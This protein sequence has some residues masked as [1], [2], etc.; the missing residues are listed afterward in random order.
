[1][2][3]FQLWKKPTKSFGAQ[4]VHAPIINPV[5]RSV[6]YSAQAG[7][8]NSHNHPSPVTEM[9]PNHIGYHDSPCLASFCFE[10]PRYTS[11][12]IWLSSAHGSFAQLHYWSVINKWHIL[13]AIYMYPVAKYQYVYLVLALNISDVFK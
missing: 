3:L 4:K 5:N 1:M 2:I 8:W 13:H 9:T 11:L 10:N 7:R 12:Y 6:I